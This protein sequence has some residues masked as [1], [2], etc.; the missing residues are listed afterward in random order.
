MRNVSKYAHAALFLCVV[1]L[2]FI[3]CQFGLEPSWK[4][5]LPVV[6]VR[7][8]PA[9]AAND[10]AI[11]RGDGFL[12]IKTLGG[13]AESAGIFYGPYNVSFGKEFT[14]QEL[15]AGA[16]KGA[17]LLHASSA[18][19]LTKSFTY[20]GETITAKDVFSSD[21]IM[22]AILAASADKETEPDISEEIQLI[23]DGLS[24]LFAGRVSFGAAG[25]FSLIAGETTKLAQT[26]IPI[27]SEDR[28][29]F[30]PDASSITASAPSLAREFYRLEGL[31]S[32]KPETAQ[33]EITFV[34]NSEVA[35]ASCSV[36]FTAVYDIYGKMLGSINT[37]SSA[38][39][40]V[41]ASRIDKFGISADGSP[42]YLYVEYSGDMRITIDLTSTDVP[43][44]G[45]MLVS[46]SPDW[47]GKKVYVSAI[48]QSVFETWLAS[49]PEDYT[50]QLPTDTL[51]I[52][53]AAVAL[54][55]TASIP[56]FDALTG[57]PAVI[58]PAKS[59]YLSAMVDMA[60]RFDSMTLQDFIALNGDY[61]S[62]EPMIGDWVTDSEMNGMILKTPDSSGVIPVGLSDF[63]LSSSVTFKGNASLAGGRLV[64]GLLPYSEPMEGKMTH[65]GFM[66]LDANGNGS[67]MLYSFADNLFT[68]L[69]LAPNVQYAIGG[70]LDMDDDFSSI[71]DISVLFS[72][73][74]ELD[75]DEGD[76]EFFK[77]SMLTVTADENGRVWLSPEMLTLFVPSVDVALSITFDEAGD[78]VLS[79]SSATLAQ[80]DTL[81]ATAP[82]GYA[83][84]VWK[85]NGNLLEAQTTNVCSI[86]PSAYPG[87]INAGSANYLT[88]EAYDGTEW[89][90]AY[91]PFTLTN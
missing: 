66:D 83:S 23:M 27:I 30:Y 76:Y 89:F 49:L 17:I 10:R 24:D 90:S 74:T 39:E 40:S 3:S 50:G 46:G 85:L 45:S 91:I 78:P 52:G 11:A 72:E 43:A 25:S 29:I 41:T 9:P 71:T 28:S 6:S 1:P 26:L 12:Y 59:Y 80:S 87:W 35:G 7:L 34:P 5:D 79:P 63:M 54:D 69:L 53:F 8:G 15:P 47:V 33:A 22:G 13:P 57:S 38:L 56:L 31:Y 51:S 36:G 55:G 81:A 2:F 84:Y 75:P 48:E 16:Y 20:A 60:G 21:E 70:F 67:A 64:F 14:T 77:E 61:S 86:V 37:S 73:T 82:A 32:V 4:S 44:S 65:A 58:D 62:F 19:D 88:L 18:L 42:F 68:P